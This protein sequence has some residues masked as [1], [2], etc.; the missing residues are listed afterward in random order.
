M[1]QNAS[2]PCGPA[3]Q[4]LEVSEVVAE[5]LSLL[6]GA[7]AALRN[8]IA[9][10]SVG[11]MRDTAKLVFEIKTFERAV[12]PEEIEACNAAA[13]R[14]VADAQAANDVTKTGKPPSAATADATLKSDV[15][16]ALNEAYQN[17]VVSQ[18]ELSVV[19]QAALTQGITLLYGTVTEALGNG[20]AGQPTDHL[21]T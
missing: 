10:L 2:A 5:S 15:V 20:Q 12:S 7:L 18:R 17:A 8:A 4:I 3:K 21:K 9:Q 13:E 16:A 19:A 11:L 14:L 1:S 6:D